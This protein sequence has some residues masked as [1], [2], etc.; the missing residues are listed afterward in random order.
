MHKFIII[1]LFLFVIATI[2]HSV[3]PGNQPASLSPIKS[4]KVGVESGE[5][6]VSHNN[7]SQIIHPGEEAITNQGGTI[8]KS[9]NPVPSTPSLPIQ[10]LSAE[11]NAVMT[12]LLLSVKNTDGEKIP[13]VTGTISQNDSVQDFSLEYASATNL[14]NLKPGTAEIQIQH[15]SF[16]T[17]ILSKTEIRPGTNECQIIAPQKALFSAILL[18]DKNGPVA[19]AD[20][21]IS[22]VSDSQKIKEADLA[23]RESNEDGRIFFN[24]LVSGE[25]IL[26]ITAPPYLPYEEIVK[27]TVKEETSVIFLSEKSQITVSVLSEHS[28]PLKG[29]NVTIQ[30]VSLE[31]GLFMAQQSTNIKGSAIF[32]KIIP[33]VCRISAKHPWC[34]DNERNSFDLVV[35]NCSHHVTLILGDRKYTI[36]GKVYENETS[37]PVANFPIQ[38]VLDIPNKLKEKTVSETKTKEDGTYTLENLHGENILFMHIM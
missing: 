1:I 9:T 5:V 15:P 20:V 32:D 18:N 21:S 13:S 27:A 16:F 2:I 36:S 34:L 25:Y 10:P 28:T 19:K 37:K 6:T 8:T 11:T 14:Y 12:S 7:Q 23:N 17:P 4:V 22:P 31:N 33:G 24:P 26:V 29:A 30:S 35:K 38:A 3:L